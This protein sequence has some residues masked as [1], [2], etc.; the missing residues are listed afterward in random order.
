MFQQE[1]K[2]SQSDSRCEWLEELTK[3]QCSSL[4]P[5]G[6]II[7]SCPSQSQGWPCDPLAE[8]TWTKWYIILLCESFNTQRMS[9]CSFSPL[10]QLPAPFQM[11]MFLKKVFRMQKLHSQT[12]MCARNRTYHRCVYIR[13]NIVYVEFNIKI[14]QICW[15][16]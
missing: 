9:S 14:N 3:I 12:G 16:I 15:K 1:G 10:P 11:G 4:L 5:H 13:K 6:R 7:L 8:E 2:W